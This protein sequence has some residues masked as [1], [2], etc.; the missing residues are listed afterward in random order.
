MGKKKRQ[1]QWTSPSG[2]TYTLGSPAPAA[3]ASPNAP[4][5]SGE[6]YGDFLTAGDLSDAAERIVEANNGRHPLLRT[7]R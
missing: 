7:I 2:V 1:T 3:P 5:R 6:G 4:E